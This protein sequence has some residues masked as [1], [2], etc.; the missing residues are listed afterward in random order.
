MQVASGKQTAGFLL[1]LRDQDTPTGVSSS[2]LERLMQATGL[3]KTEIAH[4]ALREMAERYLPKYERDDGPLT[5]DQL[6]AVRMA[7]SAT[8]TPEEN[9]TERLF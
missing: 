9:F 5:T 6:R 7:S 3:G 4:L 1:R 8:N 2:T